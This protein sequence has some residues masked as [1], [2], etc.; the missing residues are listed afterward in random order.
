[1]E[2]LMQAI[3]C[4]MPAICE[5]GSYMFRITGRQEWFHPELPADFEKRLTELIRAVK[6]ELADP[7]EVI[8]QGKVT[9]LTL[10]PAPGKNCRHHEEKAHEI[11]ARL[12]GAFEVGM[13]SGC[14]HFMFKKTGKGPAIP[15]LAE[16]VGIPPEQMAGIGDSAVDMPF[17]ER[18]GLS[19]VPAQAPDVV[20]QSVDLR[21]E[22]AAGA[23][24]IEF[25]KAAIERNLDA[26][27]ASE[28]DRQEF[29]D[30][31]NELIY[32]IYRD[33]SHTAPAS[34]HPF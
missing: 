26:T 16:Q 29:Q 15:W 17:L 21:C 22:A 25:A 11:I 33:E 13:S 31:W 5:N 28:S 8:E 1:M 24:I 32:S 3:D 20:K 18:V 4:T 14:L 30:S 6:D 10:V 27:H 9:S 12:G 2:S 19:A 23:C 34:T 7:G